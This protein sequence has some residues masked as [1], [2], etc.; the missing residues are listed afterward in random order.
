MEQNT[1]QINAR[2]I[3]VVCQANFKT[4]GT[5]LL[6]QLVFALKGKGKVSEIVYVGGNHEINPSFL[7]YVTTYV[8]PNEIEDSCENILIVPETMVYFLH[9]FKKIK[10]AIW[11][12]SVDNFVQIEGVKKRIQRYGIIHGFG[13]VIKAIKEKKVWQMPYVKEAELHLCQSY[14]AIDFVERLGVKSSKITYLSDYINDIYLESVY[15]YTS[16][17]RS[18]IVLFNPKKGITFTKKLMEYGKN[19]KWKPLINM[20]NEEIKNCLINSKVY[21]DFGNHPGKDRFPRE[22]ALAGCCVITDKE[23]SA[24]FKEDVKIPEKYKFDLDEK[25]IQ[26]IINVI[27]ECLMTYD[28]SIQ[29]FQQYRNMIM[30]EKEKFYEDVE[31]IFQ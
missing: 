14:Y 1:I 18:D 9:K 7:K 27:E 10:K 22:A 23:G 24:A 3:Y 26:N 21:I 29:D 20:T 16:K 15:D 31:R 8:Q 6:H 30:N 4:G 12:L 11:W 28:N 25:N 19:I 17:G 2:K 5:E 13:S